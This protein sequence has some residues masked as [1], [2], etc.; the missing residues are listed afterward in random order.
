[1]PQL[2]P[3]IK[4]GSKGEAVKGLQ[5][6]L[7]TKSSVVLSVDGVF[8]SRTESAVRQ[9]QSDNGLDV[10]GIVGPGTWGAL[11]VY[12]VQQGDTLSDIAREQLGDAER[13]HDLH[14]L[15]QALVSDP[16]KIHPG[17][18]LVLPIYAH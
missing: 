13:W 3:T 8:G 14:N 17:Q 10:D 12:V 4:E 15:N 2:P 16:N 18:V 5:N 6:A 9:F 11:Y 7:N 1:M